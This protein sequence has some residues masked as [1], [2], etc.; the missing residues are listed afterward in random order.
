M[1]SV[2]NGQ[3]SYQS[4]L[5][6][7]ASLKPKRTGFGEFPGHGHMEVLGEWGTQK[8]RGSSEPLP[9]H[10]ALCLSPIWPLLSYILLIINGSSSK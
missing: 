5:W 8:G 7:E 10:L 2:A 1:E 4:C 6:N 9:S 3:Q